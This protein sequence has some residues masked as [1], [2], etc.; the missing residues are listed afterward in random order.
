VS[1]HAVSDEEEAELR[2]HKQRVLV[3][4]ALSP[5]VRGAV[6]LDCQGHERSPSFIPLR[7][8][9]TGLTAGFPRMF[10][11]MGDSLS[12]QA[13]THVVNVDLGE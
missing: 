8:G 2:V 1:A 9:D 10:R 6:C 11:H 13:T 12:S 5:N 7:P 3:V 4:L